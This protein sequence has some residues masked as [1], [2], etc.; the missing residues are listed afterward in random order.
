MG[1]TDPIQPII[2]LGNTFQCGSYI[3]RIRLAEKLSL[4]FG[5]FKKGKPITLPA[6]EYAYIG[7]ALSTKGSTS[8]ALRLVR[9]GTRSGDK[10]SHQIRGQMVEYFRK[11][12]LG[13]K[14]PLPK[15][16]KK[17]HW[18]VDYLLDQPSAEIISVFIIRSD[19][20]LEAE[21]SQFL[22][23][24][25]SVFEKGLGANDIPGATH[26]LRVKADKT[27]WEDLANRLKIFL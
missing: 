9:H 13:N 2:V 14:N 27:W 12:G 11:I 7:S 5:R 21:L 3:L 1:K 20:K 10:P 18:N 22:E 23:N 25:T 6:G 16:G 26:I 19:R 8:L 4:R 24:D 17:L 15:H